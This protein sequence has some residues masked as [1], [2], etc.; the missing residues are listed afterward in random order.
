VSAW[1]SPCEKN[2]FREPEGWTLS[3]RVA[4]ANDPAAANALRAAAT[5]FMQV[6]ADGTELVPGREREG[7][8]NDAYTP[9][10][11]SDVTSTR[12]GPSLSLDCKDEITDAMRQR[13]IDV[14]MEELAAHG[15]DIAIVE[16]ADNRLKGRLVLR[17]GDDR[18][19]VW[20]RDLNGP[21]TRVMDRDLVLEHLREDLHVRK[22]AALD[23]IEQ[24]NRTGL[25]D[26][27]LTVDEVLATYP[28]GNQPGQRHSFATVEDMLAYWS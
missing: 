14:L 16:S 21:M 2:L 15:V 10:W 20:V 28:L 19:L 17:L 27:R 25:S 5:R 12:R 8:D 18:Y 26:P 3:V 22:E 9:N 23:A 24:A 1:R 4:A 13:L 6:T 11:V 7:G